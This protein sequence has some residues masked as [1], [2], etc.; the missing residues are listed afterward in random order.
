M[1]NLNLPDQ[2]E[3]ASKKSREATACQ[4]PDKELRYLIT[5]NGAKQFKHQC[6]RCGQTFQALSQKELS[7]ASKESAAPI[8]DALP[9]EHEKLRDRIFQEEFARLKAENKAKKV[10]Y[11]Q[12]YLE[13]PEW[14]K[15]R[16]KVLERAKG[17]CE[18]CCSVP[19][20]FVELFPS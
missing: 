15:K 11:Y 18:G 10:Q 17:I 8:D 20:F 1:D 12:L 16:E 5:K 9:K 19:R 7:A 4:H 6:K 14:K 13:S 2:F 3:L